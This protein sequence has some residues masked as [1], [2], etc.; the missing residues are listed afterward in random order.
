MG[1]TTVKI[2]HK[3]MEFYEMIKD[4]LPEAIVDVHTHVWRKIDYPLQR[5]QD[6][7]VV[8]WPSRVADENP[9]EDLIETYRLLLPGKK[10]TP[11]IFP[12]LPE[13]NN[14]EK[15]NNYVS[16]CSRETGYPALIFSNPAWTS[17]EL[18]EKIIKGG[19]L[20]AKSYMSMIPDLPSNQIS[21]FDFFPRH[22]LEV[23][24]KNGWIVMLHLPKDDR[25]R[26][27]ENL[28]N[29]IEIDENYENLNLIVAHVGRAYCDEDAGDAFTVLKKTKR[30][31]FDISA[32]TNENIFYQLIDCVGPERILFGSDMPITRMRMKRI[33]KNGI[34][35][36]LVPKGLY[37][38]VSKDKHMQEVEG[39]EAEKL[40]FFLYEEIGAFKRACERHKLS[41]Q[42][43]E[44]IFYQNAMK[45]IE[46][47][48]NKNGGTH[49]DS[50]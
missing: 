36:N 46:K 33:T 5:K 50:R 16:K 27:S 6:P 40:S 30:I 7:R 20:G 44:K 21:I 24:N 10:V 8:S 17:E 23:H 9:V 28:Q 29:L 43:I 3:D 42:D 11:L 37:G 34:Y 41:R 45:I 35:I 18:E 38:D 25:L 1:K 47:A 14:L 39:A 15:I 19:F 2:K 31:L 48:K 12:N 13:K 26:N 49:A 32:N 4:F 22:Q